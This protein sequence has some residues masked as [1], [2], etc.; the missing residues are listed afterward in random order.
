MLRP[1]WRF[2]PDNR[3]AE[4]FTRPLSVTG[5]MDCGPPSWSMNTNAHWACAI[6]ISN[7]LPRPLNR[8][9][10]PIGLDAGLWRKGETVVT[11]TIEN[12]Y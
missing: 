1:E 3:L 12:G 4:A 11:I 10:A 2:T 9:W 8:G 7:P 6:R 5:K